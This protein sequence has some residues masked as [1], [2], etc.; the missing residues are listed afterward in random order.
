MARSGQRVNSHFWPSRHALRLHTVRSEEGHERGGSPG[1][2]TRHAHTRPSP[3]SLMPGTVL[4]VC[5]D[6]PRRTSVTPS[7]AAREGGAPPVKWGGVS[8]EANARAGGTRAPRLHAATRDLLTEASPGRHRHAQRSAPMTPALVDS[9]G[10]RVGS[11]PEWGRAQG[12]PGGDTVPALDRAAPGIP[13]AGGGS[14]SAGPQPTPALG[15]DETSVGA[16]GIEPATTS[17]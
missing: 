8:G 11:H 2:D 16:A 6:V 13:S 17:L 7:R 9:S 10:I 3:A 1:G 4:C 14:L 15:Q 12:S 5:T